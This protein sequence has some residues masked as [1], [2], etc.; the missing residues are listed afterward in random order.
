[1]L[2]TG[3]LIQLPSLVVVTFSQSRNASVPLV[4]DIEVAALASGAAIEVGRSQR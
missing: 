2:D 4:P 1:M 3:L